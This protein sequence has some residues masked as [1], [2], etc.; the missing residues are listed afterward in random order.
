MSEVDHDGAGGSVDRLADR[1][2]YGVRLGQVQLAAQ[3][4]DDLAVGDVGIKGQHH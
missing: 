3:R 2:A 4:D 1:L